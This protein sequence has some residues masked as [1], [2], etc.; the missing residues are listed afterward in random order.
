VATACLAAVAVLLSGGERAAPAT[1]AT[2][3]RDARTAALQLGGSGPWTVVATRDWRNEP[4][5]LPGGGWGVAQV[6]Y[7]TEDWSSDAGVQLS[8]VTR[9]DDVRFARESDRAAYADRP[10]PP[11]DPNDG[12]LIR[13][14]TAGFGPTV[15]EVRALPTDPAALAARLGRDVVWRAVMLLLSPSATAELRAGLYGVLLRTP[16][17]ELVPR[18]TDPDGR[19]GEGVRFVK[20]SPPKGTAAPGGYDLTLL[21]DPRTHALLGLREGGEPGSWDVVLRIERARTAPKP[22]LEERTRDGRPEFLPI[23]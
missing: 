5:P 18:L 14:D 20:P 6:P 17:A 22:D 1:A 8:R 2:V 3:L 19:T 23:R 4:F 16:G 9:G 10:A 7:A 11:G 12:K 13:R 15:A 21:F